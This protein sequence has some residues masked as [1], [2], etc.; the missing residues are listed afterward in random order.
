MQPRTRQQAGY[1]RGTYT[2]SA[3][4]VL[5]DPDELTARLLSVFRAPGYQPPRLPKIGMQ[6]V[7]LTRRPNVN[8]RDILRLLEQDAMLSARVLQIAQSPAYTTQVP[9]QSL[10]QALMRMGFHTVSDIVLEASLQLRVF[11][12]PGYDTAMRALQPHSSATAHICRI[13]CHHTAVPNDYAFLCGLLH[14]IGIVASLIVLSD[15]RRK[16]P[17]LDYVKVAIEQAHEQAARVLADLWELPEDVVTVLENHHY[18]TIKGKV[19]PVAA[20]VTLSDWLA[21]ELGAGS[22]WPADTARA[23]EAAAA[24]GLSK[25]RM[26]EIGAEAAVVVA[27]IPKAG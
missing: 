16:P 1:G 18:F 21:T 12:A 11:R 5:V 15:G 6:L 24:I 10:Q 17:P 14:D 4:D 20:A 8:A 19:H 13:V 25:A 26:A 27:N 9:V 23:M 3:D 7:Q 22:G 2:L